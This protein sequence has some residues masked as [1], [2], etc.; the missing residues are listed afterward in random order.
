MDF[1]LQ[2]TL[3]LLLII[4]LGLLL[5][6]K[7]AKQDLN[8]IKTLILSV[9]LPATIFVALLKIELNGTLLVFPVI[10]LSFNLIMLF[11][12]KYFLSTSLPTKENAKKRT[13]LML[14][15]SSAPGLSCFPFIVAY[16]GDDAL[17]LAALADVGN[18]IFVL[19]LLYL[20]AMHWYRKRALVGK[21]VS[22]KS[23][24]KGLVRSLVNEPINMIMALGLLLLGFGLSFSSLP[25]FLQGTVLSIK[26]LMTPLVLLFIGMAVRIKRGEFKLI[27]SMLLRRAGLALLLSGSIAYFIPGLTTSMILLLVVFPQSACSFWPFAHMSA[28]NAMENKDGHPRPTFDIA[29]AVNVLACSLPFSTAL[30]LGIFSFSELFVLPAN[31]MGIGLGVLVVSFLPYLFKKTKSYFNKKAPQ[32]DQGYKISNEKTQKIAP[33]TEAQAQAS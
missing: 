32:S 17:A 9:A 6:K 23:K 22:S 29:F 4:A 20:L 19:I 18:K 30:I 28:I 31:I 26:D 5:Q 10:A 3:E 2:K 27:A 1:A 25:T 11:A 14:L 21:N 7:V 13:L 8:G 33:R 12:S 15:P 24:L 16:L